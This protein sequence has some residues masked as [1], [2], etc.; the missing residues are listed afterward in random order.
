MLSGSYEID[1]WLDGAKAEH[2]ALDLPSAE[3]VD[4]VRNGDQA[5]L[6]DS[7][8]DT[9]TH[10]VEL[11]GGA[12]RARHGAFGLARPGA[13]AR[14]SSPPPFLSHVSANTSVTWA[15]RCTWPANPRTS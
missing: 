9:A 11:T 6:W 7:S 13:H 12:G 14:N 5:W 8:T 4:L 3:E 15:T 10:L 2:L 1:V